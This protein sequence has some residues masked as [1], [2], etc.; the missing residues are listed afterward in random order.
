SS[1]VDASVYEEDRIELTY[2]YQHERLG[3]TV[4]PYYE[5]VD[6]IDSA[7]FDETRRGV[8]MQLSYRLSQTWDLRTFADV[9]RSN[10][11]DLDLRTEDTRFGVGL[12]KTWSRHWSSALDYLH[13]RRDDE[14]PFG[15]SR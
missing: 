10:F 4:G 15:D 12:S 6:F 9:A 13:Y 14:G 11:P 8:V 1:V 7:A 3:F 5:R 2:A